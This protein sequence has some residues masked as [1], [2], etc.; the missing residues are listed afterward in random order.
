MAEWSESP[1]KNDLFLVCA[2]NRHYSLFLKKET[3]F[4]KKVLPVR[5]PRAI[6]K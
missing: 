5:K 3:N 1:G 2:L 4:L 6:Y